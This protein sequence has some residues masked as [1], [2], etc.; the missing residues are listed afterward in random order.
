MATHA[1]LAAA[2]CIDAWFWGHEHSLRL[3]APYRGVAHG[4]NIGY[5]AIPVAGQTASLAPLP[6]LVDPPA[7]A[8]DVRL[9]IVDGACSHG[10]ALLDFAAGAIDASYWA[11]TRPAGAIYREPIPRGTA[12]V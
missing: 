1:H 12:G 2:G 4:R 9:D 5:G 8:V 3:Y 6:G 7:L 10:F 11:V